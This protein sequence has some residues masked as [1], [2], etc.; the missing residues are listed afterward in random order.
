MTPPR[1]S[2]FIITHNEA[3][4]LPDCLATVSALADEIVVVD[5]GSDDETC[6]IAQRAGARVIRR[7]FDGFGPQKQAALD[8]CT[9][10]WVL[11]IDADERITPEL[12]EEINAA[13]ERP[14]ADGYLIHRVVFYLGHRL[15]YGGTGNEWLLRLARRDVARF[16]PARVHE[17][18]IV[19]GNV[20]RLSA[21]LHHH[22]YRDLADHSRVI[23]RY[24][25]IIA[26]EKSR[27]GGDFSA[28]HLFRIPFELFSRLVLKLGILDGRPGIIWSAMAAHYAFLKYAKQFRATRPPPSRTHSTVQPK[29]PTPG[30]EP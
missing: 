18:M 8:A 9:G 1:L 26:E 28:F 15:R 29:T 10:E 12:G 17:R 3:A 6:A 7:A 27:A 5:Q 4:D 19:Q 25:T 22:T 30:R 13:L 11:S 24:T 20:A 23:D 21:D 16:T 2:V 14:A